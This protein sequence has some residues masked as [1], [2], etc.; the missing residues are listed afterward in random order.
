[1]HIKLTYLKNTG[2]IIDL[3]MF[4]NEMSIRMCKITI[5][6]GRP[7]GLDDGLA[8]DGDR[9]D[10]QIHSMLWRWVPYD[11]L[12]LSDGVVHLER[13]EDSL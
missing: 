4:P 3:V 1:M 11:T 5:L 2:E 7:P 8:E 12:F 9:F 10:L 13:C 6:G